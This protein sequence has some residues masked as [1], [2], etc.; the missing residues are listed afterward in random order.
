VV[1]GE[2]LPETR[3][4][5]LNKAAGMNA[6]INF[7]ADQY[8]IQDIH[9]STTKLDL[10]IAGRKEIMKE[11]YELD[12][13]GLYQA[14]NL[15]TVLSTIDVLFDKGF[16]FDIDS[17]KGALKNV[18]SLTGLH[19]RWDVLKQN[20]TLI[21]D[22]AHNEDGIRSVLK[23]LQQLNI[24]PGN[25]HFVIGMV[26]DKDVN[27]VLSLLPA[28]ATYYFCNAHIPRAMPYRE[29]QLKA[30]GHG[31]KGDGYDDVNEAVKVALGRTKPEDTIIVC[32]SVFVVGEV[33]SG[34]F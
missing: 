26:N 32:G 12:L 17:I 9:Y 1:I 6:P 10:K 11:H 13:N 25:T 31:L 21:I 4:I 33:N 29:L 30:A 8:D 28:A 24:M 20:P 22:V 34:L 14:S 2:W 23:N 3:Q 27:K 18:K 16:E 15:C 19:G 7:A 5:F